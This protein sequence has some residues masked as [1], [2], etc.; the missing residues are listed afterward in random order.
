MARRQERLDCVTFLYY[1]WGLILAEQLALSGVAL[2]GL[3]ITNT[4]LTSVLVA[5][6]ILGAAHIATK[7]MSMV[8]TGFQNVAEMAVEFIYNLV[9]SVENNERKARIFFPIVAT[10]FLYIILSN[11]AGLLP[12]VSTIG[13]YDHGHLVPMFR[14][15]MS[16]LNTTLSLALFSVV[17]AH[18]LSVKETGWSG[19]LSHWF[20]LN[21]IL[22]FVGLL[23][24]V[25][26]VTKVVSLSFRLFGNIFAGETVLEVMGHSFSTFIVP[27]PFL[28]LELIVGFAQALVFAMLTLASL[29]LL[30][31][32]HGSDSH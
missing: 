22:L 14:S 3:P 11:Y 7:K 28:G 17:T 10:F 2:G 24:L 9:Q 12:G 23:E 16:D 25:S 18:F 13:F 8:P 31:M 20:S 32:E 15:P 21:P 26:E 19:Y 1:L 29:V 30:T 4:L 5:G 27:L 6:S